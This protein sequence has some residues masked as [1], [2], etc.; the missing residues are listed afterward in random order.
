M[1]TTKESVKLYYKTG[2]LL[3]DSIK[4]Q[5]LF[6]LFALRGGLI[7]GIFPALATVMSYFLHIFSKKEESLVKIYPWFQQEF[8]KN[9]KVTNQLGYLQLG[10]LLVLWLDLRIAGQLLQN[11]LLHFGLLFFFIFT[12]LMALYLF[13][14]F[15]RYDLS[16]PQYFK[17]AFFL[18]ISNLVESLAAI[19]GMF[20]AVALATLFPILTFVSFVPLM[21]LP[22][23]WFALQGMKKIETRNLPGGPQL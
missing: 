20:V 22:I 23:T 1:K 18:V 5:F 10:I 13:P 7:L 14:A 12:L 3:L 17:Q 6:I 8:K 16:F 9:F 2:Q 4:L 21:V 11:R 15:L 19:L